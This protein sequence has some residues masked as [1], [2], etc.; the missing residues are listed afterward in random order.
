VPAG[1]IRRIQMKHTPLSIILMQRKRMERGL[2]HHG[3][4]KQLMITI[5]TTV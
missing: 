4:L 5:S 1:Q 2:R 3:P